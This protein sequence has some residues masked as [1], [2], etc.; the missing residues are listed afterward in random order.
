M[1]EGSPDEN[2]LWQLI[3]PGYIKEPL[4]MV[5][6]TGHPKC[7]TRG[8]PLSMSQPTK[9]W[10]AGSLLGPLG[11]QHTSFKGNFQ[12]LCKPWGF[13]QRHFPLHMRLVE[14][15]REK[16]GLWE[17]TCI[18]LIHLTGLWRHWANNV[19]V[20]WKVVCSFVKGKFCICN[21][22]IW[23]QSSSLHYSVFMNG[24]FPS[25]GARDSKSLTSLEHDK[26]VTHRSVGKVINF[27]LPVSDFVS[28]S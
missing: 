12:Q 10:P 5:I 26:S 22:I 15:K 20:K 6:I 2:P 23:K 24:T 25:K 16:F 11:S 14:G 8:R 7:S 19:Q 21:V 3:E 27:L 17:G 9:L 28:F 13:I 18:K 1:G 4:T